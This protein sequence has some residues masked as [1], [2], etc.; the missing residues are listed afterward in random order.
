MEFW[1]TSLI[2]EKN[3]VEKR[4]SRQEKYCITK[5][6]WTTLKDTRRAARRRAA[7]LSWPCPAGA[8]AAAVT[9]DSFFFVRGG[10]A[11]YWPSAESKSREVCGR[12]NAKGV[13]CVRG[14][15]DAIKEERGVERPAGIEHA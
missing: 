8:A 12:K 15:W 13:K 2:K 11:A 14:A 4:L 5:R 7:W 6:A 1:C 10:V 9:V 3:I